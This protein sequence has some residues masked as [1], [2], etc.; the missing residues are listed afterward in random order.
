MAQS[1]NP[2]ITQ[3]NNQYSR[4]D[5]VVENSFVA[6]TPESIILEVING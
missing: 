6:F 4:Q 3:V 5:H 1:R 2:I